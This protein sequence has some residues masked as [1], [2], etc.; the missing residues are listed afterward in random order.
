MTSSSR[1]LVGIS[2]CLF[3]AGSAIAQ[4]DRGTITGV[5]KDSQGAVVADARITATNIAT[6][7]SV[8]TTT[9]QSGDFTIPALIIGQYRVQ[10]EA[11]GFKSEVRDDVLVSAAS[12]V[13]LDVPL[14]VGAASEKVEVTAVVPPIS[15]DSSS[16]T[17]TL[18][19]KLVNDVPLEVNGQ[20]RNVFNLTTLTPDVTVGTSGLYKVAGGQDG[21]WDMQMDGMSITPTSDSKSA[22]RVI[23]TAAPIDAINEFTIESDAG[24]KAEYG[25]AMGMIN[26]ATKSGTDQFHGDVFDFFRNSAMDA[27]GFFATS[28]PRLQQNDFG[29]TVGGPVILPKLYNGKNKTFFFLAFE[30]YSEHQ[31]AQPAYFTIPTPAEL[32]GDFSGYVNSAGNMIPI[33]DPATTRPNPNGSGY[34]R[35]PFPNNQIPIGRF[36]PLAA[37]YMNLRSSSFVPNVPGAAVADNFVTQQGTVLQPFAKGTARIDETLSGTDTVGGFFMRAETTTQ[38]GPNGGPGLPA[39]YTSLTIQDIKSTYG[40]LFWT[41]T[42]DPH[43]VS[44]LRFS[45]LKGYGFVNAQSCAFPNMDWGAKVGVQNVP[46]PDQCV[47]AVTFTNTYSSMATIPGGRGRDDSWI[48]T[49]AETLT[50]VRGAHTFKAGFDFM[51]NNWAGGGSE[52]PNGVYGF[53]QLATAVPG[54]Q[55]GATGNDF[56]SFLLG[57]P[58]TVQVSTPRREVFILKNLGSFFQ[59][60][61]RVNSKLVLNLG[62]RYDYSFPIVGGGIAPGVQ[63]GFSNFSR[64]TPNPG[65]GGRLG[66]IVYTGTAP[67]RTGSADAFPTWPWEFEPRIGLAYSIRNGTVIHA[68]GS[69]GFEPLRIQGGTQ[70]YDGFITDT[71]FTSSDLDINN[72][73]AGTSLAAPPWVHPPNLTPTVDNGTGIK[74]WDPTQAGTPS[75]YWTVNFDIQQALTASTVLTVRY[76]DI[77][78]EHLTSGLLSDDQISP[79]YLTTLGP[80]LL[81]S[82]VNSAAARAAEIP[83]PYAGFNGTVEEALSPYPQYQSLGV[84]Q[85][86]RGDSTYSAMVI[87]VDRRFSRGLTMLGS[88]TLSKMFSDADSYASGSLAMNT[89]DLKLQKSLS[90]DDQTHLIRYSVSYDIPFGK[91]RAFVN[92][93]P[94]SYIIGNWTIA[95]SA[96]YSSGLPLGVTTGTTLPIGGGADRPFVTSYDNWRAP[97]TGKFKPFSDTWWNNSA[98]D[99][100][101]STVLA[102]V[103]G[104]A[105]VLNPKTR[106]PWNLN[107]NLNLARTFPIR[108]S[109]RMVVRFEGYNLLNRTVWAAPSSSALNDGSFGQIRAQSNTPRQIQLVA[110]LYF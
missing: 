47:P 87:K 20:M 85:E 95:E 64:T 67:G 42:V 98:F 13:R 99:Q 45:D 40:S 10:I 41:H 75:Q 37:S 73:P 24:M 1:V 29:A 69:R 44:D 94:L 107:E 74:W 34:I 89:F 8:S 14:E 106:L 55:S 56:A 35:T 27:K 110:K 17:T 51:K 65:A 81:T 62:L 58:N 21:G 2:V 22:A 88:Y 23:V 46:G 11:A 3:L 36:S 101:P 60:D 54:D 97:Y 96:E 91:G 6:N 70:S 9:T 4:L 49:I 105:T 82:N 76:T 66:A 25:Q 26:F 102:S 5:I 53:S 100:V 86:H 78:G 84:F 63:P 61:W 90:A 72:F 68:S 28:N 43:D 80:A 108:E 12:V 77:R 57:Y 31:G 59:D 104:N 48:W 15:S 30:G 39:P 32:Q 38:A 16:V 7:V 109:L 52:A 83:I 93:G 92:Q 19:N 103:M 33:Y 71:T 18:G 50:M 79:S